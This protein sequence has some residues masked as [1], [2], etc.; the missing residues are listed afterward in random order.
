MQL[1]GR[2]GGRG[3]RVQGSR[4]KSGGEEEKQEEAGVEKG[5]KGAATRGSLRTAPRGAARAGTSPPRPG[6]CAS[7]HLPRH[8]ARE[9]HLAPPRVPA[10]RPRPQVSLAPPRVRA[11]ATRR[12][13]LCFRG[14][15]RSW[16][17]GVSGDWAGPGQVAPPGRRRG[18][19]RVSSSA[20]S[21]GP[22]CRPSRPL[23]RGPLHTPKRPFFP[24]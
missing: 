20:L 22:C 24:F 23:P 9:P 3:K 7:P 6:P 13:C 5:E 10:D 17:R 19:E 14:S 15:A 21:P 1:E 4:D 11:R 12:S 2:D 8:R 18:R 16:G